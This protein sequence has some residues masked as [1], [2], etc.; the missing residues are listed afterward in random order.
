MERWGEHVKIEEYV[1]GQKLVVSYCRWVVL[2]FYLLHVFS[3]LLFVS[4]HFAQIYKNYY[5][6]N[7]SA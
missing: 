5:Q 6:Q 1:P 7:I 4:L 3:I 2:K